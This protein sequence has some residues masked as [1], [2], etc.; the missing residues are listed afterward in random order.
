MY[1]LNRVTN[2][3][4]KAEDIISLVDPDA[5]QSVDWNGDGSDV[6]THHCRSEE[7]VAAQLLPPF[8]LRMLQQR[9]SS[10]L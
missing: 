2:R 6:G 9:G 1:S 5:G 4:L 10:F 7:A 8:Y 3:W